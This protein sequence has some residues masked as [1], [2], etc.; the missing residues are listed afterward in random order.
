[1]ILGKCQDLVDAFCLNAAQNCYPPT[2]EG[3]CQNA[4][5]REMPCEDAVAVIAP[6]ERRRAHEIAQFGTR[7]GV[8]VVSTSPAESVT[9]AG[10]TW[11]VSVVAADRPPADWSTAGYDAGRALVVAVRKFG[12]EILKADHSTQRMP[13]KSKVSFA[14][15]ARRSCGR[16]SPR[17]ASSGA[18]S[19]SAC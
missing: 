10:S 3:V 11:V 15:C 13:P 8:P 4:F 17:W 12:G 18:P 1:M 2:L 6:P 7:A 9:Q 16:S 19:P 5:A 14:I